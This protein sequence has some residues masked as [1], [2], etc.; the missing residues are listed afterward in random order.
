MGAF[1]QAHLCSC[2]LRFKDGECVVQRGSP[3]SSLALVAAPTCVGAIIQARLC[4]CGA[5]A[6]TTLVLDGELEA[7]KCAWMSPPRP[8]GGQQDRHCSCATAT[9]HQLDGG[10]HEAAAGGLAGGSYAHQERAPHRKTQ[11]SSP[12]RAP[13]ARHSS[14]NTNAPLEKSERGVRYRTPRSLF[15]LRCLVSCA[16]AQDARCGLL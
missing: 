16:R 5:R 1:I 6:R 7:Y 13:E 12:D 15:F 4:S 2:G 3:R 11:N 9:R 10:L 14:H 8:F